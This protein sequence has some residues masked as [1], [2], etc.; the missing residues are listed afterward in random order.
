MD[1]RDNRQRWAE[2]HQVVHFYAGQWCTFTPALT[3]IQ[4]YAK[5]QERKLPDDFEV[6]VYYHIN[7]NDDYEAALTESKRYLDAYYTEDYTREFVDM[8][9]AVGP[10]ERCIAEIQKFIDAGATTI[11]LRLSG[12]DQKKQYERVTNEVLPVFA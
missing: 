9:A 10:V 7:I 2:S 12:Y 1:Y 11:T 6:A 5:E 4:G 3:E 8:W